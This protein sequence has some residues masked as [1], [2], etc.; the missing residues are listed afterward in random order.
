LNQNDFF[1]KIKIQLLCD[2]LDTFKNFGTSRVSNFAKLRKTEL[3]DFCRAPIKIIS[4]LNELVS[5]EVDHRRVPDTCWHSVPFPESG[6]LSRPAKGP[7]SPRGHARGQRS[8]EQRL[9]L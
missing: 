4:P 8:R 3:A 2:I 1:A 6:W 5:V 9:R 7:W